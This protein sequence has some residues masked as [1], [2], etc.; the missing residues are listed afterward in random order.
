MGWLEKQKDKL[1]KNRL[2]LLID[3]LE[4]FEVE[5]GLKGVRISFEDK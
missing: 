5:G 3:R 1:N 2:G 4:I